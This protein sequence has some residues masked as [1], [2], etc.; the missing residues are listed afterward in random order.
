M[1]TS[2]P[3]SLSSGD[4]TEADSLKVRLCNN[5]RPYPPSAFSLQPSASPPEQNSSRK[6]DLPACL[7][8]IRRFD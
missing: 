2:P 3:A 8:F 7:S 4:S 5:R 1:T 6:N